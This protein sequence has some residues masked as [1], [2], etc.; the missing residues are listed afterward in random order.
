LAGQK[1]DRASISSVNPNPNLNQ[2]SRI[3]MKRIK[4]Y[5]GFTIIE[6]IM[7][8]AASSIIVLTIGVVMLDT[9]RGWMDSYA[10]IH[11]GAAADAIMRGFT[12]PRT[13]PPSCISSTENSMGMKKKVF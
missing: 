9:Q 13:L 4:Y 8:I 1:A 7:A 6:L 12:A 11:G 3:I 5:F 2:R 10:K